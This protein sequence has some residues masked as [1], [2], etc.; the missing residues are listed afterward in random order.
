[1][2]IC[3]YRTGVLWDASRP[4][5]QGTGDRPIAWSAWYPTKDTG[6][7][8][9]LSGQFFDLG[10]VIWNATLTA[11]TNLPVVML[12]H[13]TG[14]TAESLGWLARALACKGHVVIGANHH[15]NTGVDQ[16]HAAG[17]LC[18]WERAADLSVL[19][20]SLGSSEFFAQRLDF[21]NVSAVGFSLGGYSVLALAGAQSSTVEFE[22][23]LRINNITTRGPKEFP[24]AVDQ[25]PVL[26][27]TSEPFQQSWA[28]QGN[29]FTDSRIASLVAIAPAPPV[30]AFTPQSVAQ[31]QLPVTILTGNADSEAP[32]EH[33]ANW[34]VQQNAGFQHFDLG[35]QVGHY[36]F[37]EFPAD[38]TL[39]RQVDIFS[40]HKDVDR[41][42]VHERATRFVLQALT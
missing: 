32:S 24:D 20:T 28:R 23:W 18:W 37:L 36:T 8:A 4:N 41:K 38:K 27:R 17:F 21:D 9:E 7:I 2:A 26:A 5:W 40:D 35:Q 29:D 16:Y 34:L 39:V 10:D 12:S 15:G 14:G 11:Q 33:C 19:L 31:I 30:R 42:N 25:I 22:T 6:D 13:G 1:M 3:G